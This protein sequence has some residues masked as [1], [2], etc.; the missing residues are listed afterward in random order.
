MLL[1]SF[2]VHNL[3][4]AYD[5]YENPP[6]PDIRIDVYTH[7][8]S[9]FGLVA[10]LFNLN[11]SRQRSR[12]YTWGIPILGAFALGVVWELFEEFVIRLN[13]IAFYN[14]FWNAVQDMYMDL[15]GG[16]AV[17]FLVDEIVL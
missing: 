16:I 5:I 4:M 11:L 7:S 10:L 2:G 12:W 6:H 8:L 13:L 14:S 3:A 1:G 17:A 15:L 9:T